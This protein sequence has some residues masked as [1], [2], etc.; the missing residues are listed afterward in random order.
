MKTFTAPNGRQVSETVTDSGVTGWTDA[1]IPTEALRG[2]RE[3]LLR[4]MASD[5]QV[6]HAEEIAEIEQLRKT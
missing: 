5:A 1:S 6:Q 2:W 3:Q 4:R